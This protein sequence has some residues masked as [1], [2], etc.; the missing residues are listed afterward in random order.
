MRTPLITIDALRRDHLSCYGYHRE[1]TPFLKKLA[2]ENSIFRNCYAASCHT[3]E[4]IPSILTGKRPENCV[5]NSY[6]INSETIPESLPNN[7]STE[8][9]TT[10]CYLTEVENHSRGFDS[11]NSDY[12]LENSFLTRQIE[13][14][15]RVLLNRPFKSAET[16]ID[17]T[18]E[19][20]EKN[21]DFIWTHLMDIHAPY[22]MFDE[23]YWGDKVS[24]RKLQYMFRK[25]KHFPSS[26]TE[27]ERQILVDAYDNSIRYIDSQLERLLSNISDDIEVFIV[28]DHGENLGENGKYEHPRELT[29]QLLKAPLIVRNGTDKDLDKTVSTSDIA[30]TITERYRS[31]I[32]GAGRNLFSSKAQSVEASCL[33]EGERIYRDI[34]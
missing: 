16:Q 15:G 12:V 24:R 32:E 7:V 6:R 9:L 17:R 2:E 25:A 10:G 31:R 4:A 3:R 26:V 34:A 28:G 8:A 27:E 30:P 23:W 13:Y 18:I 19:S 29:D 33:R 5:D 1:T 20:L 11:F 14:I 22:N 21:H